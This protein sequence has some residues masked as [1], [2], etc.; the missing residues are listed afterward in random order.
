MEA[1][2]GAR[3]FMRLLTESKAE[4]VAFDYSAAVDACQDNNGSFA[5]VT[6]LQCDNGR[7]WERGSLRAISF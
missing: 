5:N 2:S 1:G 6:L 3:R 4:V 7:P